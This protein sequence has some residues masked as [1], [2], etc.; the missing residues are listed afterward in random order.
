MRIGVAGLNAAGKTEVVGLLERRGFYRTSLSDVIRSEL[1]LESVEPTREEMI[2]RGRAL[3]ERYG[4]GV[5]AER[6]RASLPEGRNHVIDSIRHPAE[7]RQRSRRD[8]ARPVS[9]RA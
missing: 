7:R 9:E 2:A 4:L 6:V 3:R 1:R 5:L 8:R